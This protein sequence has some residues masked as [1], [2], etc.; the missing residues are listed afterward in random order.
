[1]SHTHTHTQSHTQDGERKERANKLKI[2]TQNMGGFGLEVRSH[3][4]E[5]KSDQRCNTLGNV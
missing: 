1:M 5:R 4:I 3:N 2:A